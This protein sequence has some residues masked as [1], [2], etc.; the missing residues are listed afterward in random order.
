MANDDEQTEGIDVGELLGARTEEEYAP[1]H[2]DTHIMAPAP[3]PASSPTDS[4]ERPNEEHTVPLPRPEPTLADAVAPSSDATDQETTR[5]RAR[6]VPNRIGRYTIVDRL[7]A[8]GMA[9]VF[10]AR[11]DGPGGFEK[12][13]VI[14]RSLTHLRETPRFVEMFVREARI[15]ARLNHPNIVQIYEL[16]KDGEDYFIAMEHVDGISLHRL[17]RRAWRKNLAVPMEVVL[18]AVADAA[19]GLGHAHGLVDAEGRSQNLVHRDISPDNLMVDKQ[20]VT[21]VLDFGIAKASDTQTV[22]KSG[23]IKG[24]IP[25]MSPEQVRGEP[26]D[27]RTDL[28]ALGV[29]LYWLLTGQ[30]PFVGPSDF[31]TMN[32][33]LE[34]APRPPSALN[35]RVPPA[36]DAIVLRLLAKQPHARYASGDELAAEIDELIPAGRRESVDFVAKAIT[37]PDAPPGDLVPSDNF[38]PATPLSARLLRPD[39]LEALRSTA[40]AGRTPFGRRRWAAAAL[41]GG[42]VFLATVGT[43][44]GLMLPDRST[45]EEPVAQ[46]RVVATPVH[47]ADKPAPS[48]E[49]TQP[50]SPAPAPVAESAP[51]PEAAPAVAP[52]TPAAASAAPAAT[53]PRPRPKPSP[54]RSARPRLTTLSTSAPDGI[55]WRAGGDV[56]GTGSGTIEVPAQTRTVNASDPR[57]GHEVTFNVGAGALDFA[58]LGVGTVEFRIFPYADVQIGRTKL[59]TTPMPGQKLTAGKYRATL[60]FEEQT[61]KVSFRIEAGKN[62]TV[63]WS[64]SER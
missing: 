29:C 6:G 40:P 52:P 10:L 42:L 28:Y 39:S 20:G 14:K 19:T 9:E 30:R 45:P 53:K 5:M 47:A 4:H 38:L 7:G 33:V 41:V 17:A 58:K 18:R 61:A 3:G 46:A 8:G 13:V 36:V 22:T 64:F 63:K 24:K 15:A 11:Q 48:A 32:A 54:K 55:V 25:F 26:L 2:D 60:R 31:L 23:E 59:G 1:E 34:E 16:G 57:R 44:V 27:H 37:L 62:T 56:V 49:A 21:K 50:K 51:Q 35:P 12:E 43:L